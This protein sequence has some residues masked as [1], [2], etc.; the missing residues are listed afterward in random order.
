M[1]VQSCVR[2][3]FCN[4]D[5]DPSWFSGQ[6]PAW[7]SIGSLERYHLVHR[8]SN[9]FSRGRSGFQR[10]HMP[11][12]EFYL[13]DQGL[14]FIQAM[15]QKFPDEGPDPAAGG[16]RGGGRGGRSFGEGGRRRGDFAGYPKTFDMSQASEEDRE[17]FNE[18]EEALDELCSTGRVGAA[19]EFKRMSV[20]RRKHLHHLC[21]NVKPDQ[22]KVQLKHESTPG[23]VSLSVCLHVSLARA[24]SFRRARATVLCITN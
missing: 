16:H 20:L 21:D 12:D 5:M 24:R 23:G 15:L 19:K 2:Q 9:Q 6:T 11:R 8:N 18:D 17:H 3:P 7:R 14:K 4:D 13:T 22:F 10:G 1:R